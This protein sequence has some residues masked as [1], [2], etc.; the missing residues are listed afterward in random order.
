MIGVKFVPT[1][2]V[3]SNMALEK[4]LARLVCRTCWRVAFELRPSRD[5]QGD[6]FY[7]AASHYSVLHSP[8][9]TLRC[10]PLRSRCPHRLRARR[11]VA[12]KVLRQRAEPQ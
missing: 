2:D 5:E 6:R 12:G 3:L 1:L 9:C 11:G 8:Y 10:L 7:S 4:E